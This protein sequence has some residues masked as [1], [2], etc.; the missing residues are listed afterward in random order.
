[1]FDNKRSKVIFIIFL[2]TILIIKFFSRYK[3]WSISGSGDAIA[4][5][6]NSEM[7]AYATGKTIDNKI[8]SYATT[9]GSS[10]VEIRKVNNAKI[11]Q[12]FNFFSASSIAFSPDN[13][14][15]A[16]GGYGGEIKVWRLRDARLIHS[17][18]KAERYRDQTEGLFF[19]PDGRTLIS[20]TTPLHKSQLYHRTSQLSVFHLE[21]NQNSYTIS[22]PF[23]CATAS[24]DGQLMAIAGTR[25][26]IT[27]Y[28]VLDGKLLRRIRTVPLSCYNIFFSQDNQSV[29]SEFKPT[30]AGDVFLHRVDDGK[31]L[32]SIDRFS[33]SEG[34][35][36]P[37]DTKLSPNGNFIA[38]SYGAR[39]GGGDSLFVNAPELDFSLGLFGY[40]HFWHLKSGL[41]FPVASI[42]AHWMNAKAI[43]FSPDGKWLASVSGSKDRNRVRLW[44]MPPY[45]GWWWFLGSI[46]LAIFVYQRRVEL[47]NWLEQ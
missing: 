10:T 19:T 30:K 44:R 1:M 33:L 6:P 5:S 43:A 34:T 16:I 37:T 42:R 17:F 47:K 31:L 14:L 11:I 20:S 38:T 3:S 21:Q 24:P 28:R 18:K 32:R 7:I 36:D 2:A 12:T 29:I 4:F 13:S 27:I 41:D 39:S 9:Y 25:D 26:Y 45:S 46:G 15:I 40:V 35:H 22:E 8:S 23:T